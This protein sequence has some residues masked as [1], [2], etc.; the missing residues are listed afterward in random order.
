MYKNKNVLVTGGTGLIGR[1]LVELLL[2]AEAKVR[3]V[4][5]DDPSRCPEGAEFVKGNLMHLDICRQI[6][7]GMD[8]V[9]HV[10]GNKGSVR[11]GVSRAASF[12]VP[13]LMMNTNM[14][15]AAR[16][17]GV[18]RYLFTSS[19]AV[20]PPAQILSEDDA[21]SS[22]P[23][24][25]DRYAAWM[26]RIGELQAEAYK[27]EYGWDKIAI[28]RPT[29]VYGPWDNFDPESAMAVATLIRRVLD[30]E[31]P[32]VVWGD[33]SAVRDFIY[34]RDVAHGMMLALEKGANCTPINLGTGKGASI[35][36][37][38][39][40]IVSFVHE[41]PLIRWDAEKQTG[42]SIRLMDM[43]RAKEMLGFE[44][45]TSL[46]EGIKETMQWYL[47]NRDVANKRYNVFRQG[48]SDG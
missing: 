47:A 11:L 40:T 19:V 30:G 25:T 45:K 22:N 21:W 24:P 14:M 23:H 43:T 7:E 31:N 12:F 2:E 6:A 33:G 29:G 27:Q 1:P 34:S 17:A 41:P 39:E 46:R 32:L 37:L 48:I 36:E 16:Q 42:E 4:S 5:M 18:E 44:A 9:F 8:Y 20:Y 3:V 35:K 38:V 13:A 26:K 10:A 15:E 28:V